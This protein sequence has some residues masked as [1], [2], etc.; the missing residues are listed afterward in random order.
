M[1]KEHWPEFPL[2]WM[3]QSKRKMEGLQDIASHLHDKTVLGRNSRVGFV[4]DANEIEKQ[5]ITNL[6]AVEQQVYVLTDVVQ[7][8][9]QIIA[10][11]NYRKSHRVKRA[12]AWIQET[13]KK[14]ERKLAANVF[15]RILAIIGT[16]ATVGL[17]FGIGKLLIHFLR[18]LRK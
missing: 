6:I 17:L 10:E 7:A 15:Y 3:D 13:A 18:G 9:I 2:W 16:L 1:N 5:I 4:G 11:D 14:Y 12:L 8:A